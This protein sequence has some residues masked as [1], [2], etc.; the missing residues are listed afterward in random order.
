[1]DRDADDEE[2]VRFVTARS[3]ALLRYGYVLAGEPHT[4]ADLVQEALLRLRSAWA[5]GKGREHPEA[6]ARVTMSRLHISWW[7]RRR[8]EQLTAL[9][10]DRT[11]L[12]PAL[13]RVEDDTGLWRALEVLGRRQRAVIVLRYYEGLGDD[14]IA[15]ILGIA[16]VTVRSQAVRALRRLRSHLTDD[17][18]AA[19][20]VVDTERSN[21]A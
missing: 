2:F 3:R 6:Y 20:S 8:G 4:A 18:I 19:L 21:R 15:E 10:P 7:R 5:R 9:V 13:R 11:A 14:E 16:E 1:M 12:D 17:R